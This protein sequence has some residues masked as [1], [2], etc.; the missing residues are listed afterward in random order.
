MLI[1]H[2]KITI[3]NIILIEIFGTI[4]VLH[5]N[6]RTCSTIMFLNDLLVN[7]TNL[8]FCDSRELP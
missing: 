6:N 8:L 1:N 5:K 4:S 2:H 3:K 7:I